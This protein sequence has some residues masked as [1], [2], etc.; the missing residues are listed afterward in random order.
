M[1]CRIGLG[2]V[3]AGMV[4]GCLAGDESAA[5][6]SETAPLSVG[7]PLGD[8]NSDG[9]ADTRDAIHYLQG[10]GIQF[11]TYGVT[12]DTHNPGVDYPRRPWDWNVKVVAD[13]C[14]AAKGMTSQPFPIER[15]PG[16]HQMMTSYL[17]LPQQYLRE[18]GAQGYTLILGADLGR[19]HKR[20]NMTANGTR[21]EVILYRVTGGSRGH[22]RFGSNAFKND[23]PWE[24]IDQ[25]SYVA[26]TGR[27]SF[28]RPAA[29][30]VYTGTVNSASDGIGT[31]T[32]MTGSFTWS[33][34]TYPFSA[35]PTYSRGGT[36]AEGGFGTTPGTCQED[37][38]A[39]GHTGKA[40]ALGAG[41]LAGD[42]PIHELGHVIRYMVRDQKIHFQ[43]SD[44][45][46][47]LELFQGNAEVRDGCSESALAGSGVTDCYAS[48][49]ADEDFAETWM[50][51]VPYSTSDTGAAHL[52]AR[53]DEDLDAGD[54]RLLEKRNFLREVIDTPDPG[55]AVAVHPATGQHYRFST[56][57]TIRYSTPD[58]AAAPLPGGGTSHVA[59]SVLSNDV[60][61]LWL[62][63]VGTDNRVYRQSIDGR[64]AFSGF[65]SL[66]HATRLPVAPT[67]VASGVMAAFMVDGAG[68]IGYR[69]LSSINGAAGSAGVIPG[70]TT[71]EPIAVATLG[72]RTY[73]FAI[74]AAGR[75]RMNALTYVPA[76]ASF[77]ASGWSDFGRNARGVSAVR[78]LVAGVS[79]LYVLAVDERMRVHYRVVTSPTALGTW[80]AEPSASWV[81]AIPVLS[82]DRWV[83]AKGFDGK[84]YR[85]P[86]AGTAG[87]TLVPGL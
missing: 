82:S 74:D 69:F 39:I 49:N 6:E 4:S 64:G 38:W 56:G 2:I 7:L 75:V 36:T 81:A 35:V 71:S 47:I 61:K 87:M 68:G 14:L 22:A 42:L 52:A 51:Y 58:L 46:R 40:I 54:T 20:W 13:E 44:R 19:F 28:R 29:A 48:S 31:G 57:R 84:I 27:F 25:I 9:V 24:A 62:F 3:A 53:I 65:T 32:A 79:S 30:Q 33:G 59:V 45:T 12:D 78:S 86:L 26:A 85:K 80:Q 73:L 10:F 1:R 8:L 63:A 50:H 37:A 23:A 34:N 41:G 70:L 18:L 5:I 17:R 55:P 60:D 77:T 43:A 83:Y 76:T 66:G 16:L 15:L 72:G 67:L 21:A 11:R